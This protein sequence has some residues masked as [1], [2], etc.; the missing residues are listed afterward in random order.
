[1]HRHIVTVS[2]SRDQAILP[3]DFDV[4][5]AIKEK[6][7]YSLGS[8]CLYPSCVQ[9]IS[10]AVLYF[11]GDIFGD[12]DDFEDCEDEGEVEEDEY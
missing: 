8:C 7:N 3:V 9:V 1:M 5:F 11:T 4:G 6:V 2:A 10:R 12:D